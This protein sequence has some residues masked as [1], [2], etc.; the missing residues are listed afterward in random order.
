MLVRGIYWNGGS[1]LSDKYKESIPGVYAIERR[2][3]GH[4]YEENKPQIK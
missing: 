1:G 3:W 4:S 2:Y